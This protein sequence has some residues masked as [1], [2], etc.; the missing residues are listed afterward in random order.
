MLSLEG[1]NKVCKEQASK[2]KIDSYDIHW[3]PFLLCAGLVLLFV[4]V[5][6][7]W[8]LVGAIL[9]ALCSWFMLALLYLDGLAPHTCDPLSLM[10]TIAAVVQGTSSAWSLCN[11]F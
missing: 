5:G 1:W 6:E 8:P 2:I 10:V 7:K 9:G 11:F 3:N 4:Y